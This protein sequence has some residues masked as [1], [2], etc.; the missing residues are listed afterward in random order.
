MLAT[1]QCDG[2]MPDG[3]TCDQWT[4]RRCARMAM[5]VQKRDPK[6]GRR[7]CDTRD[8]CPDCVEAGRSVWKA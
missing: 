8:L 3:T 1:L 4:C 6:T 7:H 2:K 5:H